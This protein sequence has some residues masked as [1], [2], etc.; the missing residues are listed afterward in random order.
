M[1]LYYILFYQRMNML[2]NKKQSRGKQLLR[3]YFIRKQWLLIIGIVCVA[4][5]MRSPITAVGPVIS[6]IKADLQ[7]SNTLAGLITTLPLLAFAFFSP[8]VPK[9][10]RK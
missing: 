3:F 9:L 5:T 4:A 6:L 10:V 1:F 2:S 7:I 8:I